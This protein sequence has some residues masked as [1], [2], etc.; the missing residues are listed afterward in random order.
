MPEKRARSSRLK[1]KA[2]WSL[3]GLS[4]SALKLPVVS[5]CAAF[6]AGVPT[7]NS[8]V[9]TGKTASPDPRMVSPIPRKA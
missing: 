2:A 6:S 1:K 8:D 3:A 7:D 5:A 9:R 4:T